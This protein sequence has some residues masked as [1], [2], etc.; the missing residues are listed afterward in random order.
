MDLQPLLESYQS[1]LPWNLA[2]TKCF[3]SMILGVIASG[4]VQQHKASL[5]FEGKAK[6]KS[7]CERIRCFL[8]DFNFDFC[9]F[10][11]VIVAMTGLKGPFS[12]SLDRTN[13]QFGRL[14]INLLVLAVHVGEQFSVPILWKALPK[15]GNSNSQERIDLLQTFI[16]VFGC[17]RI[18][19]LSADREFI[20]KPW[21]DYLI[22]NRIPFFIRIKENRLVEWGDEM[23]PIGKFFRH[24]KKNEKRNIRFILG[25]HPLCFAG[26][27]SSKGDLVIIMSNQDKGNGLLDIYKKRWTI[28]V[29]FGNIKKNG[30]NLE[31]THLTDLKRIEKLLAVVVSALL[32]CFLAGRR[33][34]KQTKT[35][36]KKTKNT[37]AFSTFRRGFDYLR[38]ILFQKKEH[39]FSLILSLIHPPN[40]RH[41]LSPHKILGW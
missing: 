38:K 4:S 23:K 16:D 30:F 17:K 12:L 39:A 24:L 34:E 18:G 32:L 29:L 35:P 1:L 26:T 10:A 27:R 14:D 9:A 33:A 11:R 19:S 6:Q 28:E 2:R 25:G 36:F 8:K 3:V 40:P 7:V 21:I 13:W 37:P 20:G 5:A 31:D 15:K 41:P 22:K